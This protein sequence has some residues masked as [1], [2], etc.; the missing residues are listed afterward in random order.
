[1]KKIN[2]ERKISIAEAVR[3]VVSRHPSILDCLRL[4]IGNY[5]S[6]GRKIY[7][8]VVEALGGRYPSLYAIKIALKRYAEYLNRNISSYEG[9]IKDILRNSQLEMINDVTVYTL[10][11]KEFFRKMG[12][13]LE[14]ISE[15]H[16]IQVTQG[17]RSI[18]IVADRIA[19]SEISK[20]INESDILDVMNNQSAIIIV[21]PKD[22]IEVPGVVNYITSLLFYEG[23]NITQIISSYIDTI[24]IVDRRDSLRTYQVLE[25]E[26]RGCR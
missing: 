6:I 12:T 17:R 11:S 9:R 7:D 22:I 16:F 8:E 18:T 10:R 14:K 15:G 4:N 5:S 13:I 25:K 1:M 23:I 19:S 20:Y 24:V 21:S 26:I 3:I 2:E